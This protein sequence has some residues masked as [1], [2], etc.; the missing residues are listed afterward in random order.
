MRGEQSPRP[1]PAGCDLCPARA[2]GWV[3]GANAFSCSSGRGRRTETAVGPR[4][5][6][7][8]V[9][10][11]W[12]SGH[13]Q[14]WGPGGSVISFPFGACPAGSSLLAPLLEPSVRQ[15]AA[16]V[17]PVSHLELM[18]HF[19]GWLPRLWA[20]CKGP[21]QQQPP[22]MRV[23]LTPPT[24]HPA[25]SQPGPQASEHPHSPQL[26]PRVSALTAHPCCRPPH[27]PWGAASARA[28]WT[29]PLD[30]FAWGARLPPRWAAVTPGTLA[31]RT[32]LGL[33]RGSL[34]AGTCVHI[35]LHG[36]SEKMLYLVRIKIL[37]KCWLF[38]VCCFIEE[39]GF[40][41]R[42]DNNLLC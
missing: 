27:G 42:V 22:L 17:A 5:P 29:V 31:A 14:A 41:G 24:R 12:P 32:L 28:G 18:G 34:P 10:R 13:P 3:S 30:F 6:V 9:C 39:F 26:G 25:P 37:K 23:P 8:W 21:S 35:E 1:C 19:P 7:H 33:P 15:P 2:R 16:R 40:F 20:P 4:P 36:L 38:S 11:R